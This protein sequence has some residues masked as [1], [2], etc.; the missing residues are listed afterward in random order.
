MP[1]QKEIDDFAVL[2]SQAYRAVYDVFERTASAEGVALKPLGRECFEVSKPPART[3]VQVLGSLL[4]EQLPRKHVANGR[5]V[6]PQNRISVLLS[7]RDIYGFNDS[8]P[9]SNRSYLHESFVNIGYYRVTTKKWVTLLSLRYDF[10]SRGATQGHPIFHAQLSNGQPGESIS[11]LPT[12]PEI[13]TLPSDEVYADVRMPTAN[14]IGASALLKLAADHLTHDSF[15]TVLQKTQALPFF[16]NWRCNCSTLD[17]QDSVRGL[18]AM[19]WYG[20]KTS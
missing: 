3:T 17:N 12:V 2:A 6:P 5:T 1:T 19:G 13:T 15:T 11:R 20:C 18:L 4:V 8:E 16:R 14:M 10:G 9:S 7:S